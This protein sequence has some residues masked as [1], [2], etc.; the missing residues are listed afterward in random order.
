VE[1]LTKKYVKHQANTPEDDLLDDLMKKD[2]STLSD[3]GWTMQS[4]SS[5]QDVGEVRAVIVTFERPKP[6]NSI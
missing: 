1:K 5:T 4:V 3:Q 2:I 6:N